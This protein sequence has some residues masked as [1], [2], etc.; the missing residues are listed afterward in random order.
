MCI[1]DRTSPLTPS[2]PQ[3]IKIT[4]T[5]GTT[6]EGCFFGLEGIQL[7]SNNYSTSSGGSETTTDKIY[8]IK[9][10]NNTT[11]YLAE[12]TSGN[13][14]VDSYSV[15]KKVFWRFIPT[16]NTD[17]YYIQNTA[18]GRYIGSCNMAPDNSSVV[19]MSDDPVE[20][21]TGAST[22]TSGDNTGCVWLCSTDFADY[23]TA[24]SSS[25][26]ALNKSGANEGQ[27][28]TW[29]NGTTNVGSYWLLTE[30]EDLYE[31]QPF[32]PSSSL[33]TPKALY[34]LINSDGLSWN[35]TEWTAVSETDANQQWYFVGTSNSDGGYQI[36][37]AQDK[38]ALN[39]KQYKVY[40]TAST[41]FYTFKDSDGNVLSFAGTDAVKF[42]ACRSA[43]A[44]SHQLY[45]MPCGSTGSV[46]VQT[47]TIGSDYHYP[48]GVKSGDAI[49]YNSGSNTKYVMLSNDE[50]IIDTDGAEM[51]INLNS[52]PGDYKLT[53]F[54]DWNHDGVF[55]T[56]YEPTQAQSTSFTLLPTE[57]ALKGVT[58]V[59]IR[60][61]DNGLTDPEDD[62]H[63]Q[64][65]DLFVNLIDK[66]TDTVT[67]TVKVNA[68][69]RGT[70]VYENGTAKAT[71][72]GNSLFVCWKENKRVTSLDNEWTTAP[73]STPRVL[74][75][76]LSANTEDDKTLDLEVLQRVDSEAVIS[77]RGNV[78]TVK[79]AAGVDHIYVFTTNGQT[80]AAAHGA[81][82]LT[83]NAPAGVYI[84]RIQTV[85][86][87]S[88][89][90]I[91]KL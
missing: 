41:G 52:A 76:V 30:T 60:L 46:Y 37:N 40:D 15:N 24:S 78:I 85:K 6:N 90:R 49:S 57:D 72:K 48:M 70:A 33:T 62:V 55:E 56:K 91:I 11:T 9:W 28:I 89:H 75:A 39:S 32:T 54:A 16:G 43:F 87:S 67:P 22:A 68:A 51:T 73:T 34:H 65:I 61:T 36:A 2:S 38:A 42:K 63:G 7:T 82:S 14:T 69:E 58:R 50:A 8:T 23:A 17:C 10:K 26:R 77:A 5:K 86:G 31:L 79:A 1:R 21:Y 88:A 19:S 45:N 66:S 25:G 59:R 29:Y 27:I 74:T 83:V 71:T 13:L 64:V 44:L 80:A 53:V 35:G 84:V 4:V 3:I 47:A 18:S 20:Y 12:G 81:D